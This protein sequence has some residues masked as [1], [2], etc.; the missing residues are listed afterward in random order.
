MSTFSMNGVLTVAPK[1]I[2]GTAMVADPT[3]VQL[4]L[5]SGSGSGQANAYWSTAL[6]IAAG[7][8]TSFDLS[9]LAVSQFGTTGTL[10]VAAVKSL[11]IVNG[12]S[13]VKLTVEPG[14]S[15][16][17][18]Q[19]CGAYVGKGGCMFWHAPVDGLPASG[20]SGV[21]KITNNDTVVTLSGDTTSGSAVV[22]MADTTGVEVG[23]VVSGTG[24]AS[25]A[26][27]AS[28][29]AGTSVTLTA[30]A[31]ATGTGVS[32]DF[33]WPDAVVKVFVAGVLD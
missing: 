20:S 11:G 25:G 16:G 2:D 5:G 12:S 10:N 21:V 8:N 18:D 27:V 31:T 15:N 7:D 13:H 23:M 9:A 4:L 19:L 6:T 3:Q 30:N 14:A 24:I 17:W 33:H 1:W 29:V 32:L 22:T 26:K 28:I